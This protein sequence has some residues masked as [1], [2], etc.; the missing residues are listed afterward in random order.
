MWRTKGSYLYRTES[1]TS[2]SLTHT[3]DIIPPNNFAKTAL[4]LFLS[5]KIMSSSH[6]NQIAFAPGC[7]HLLPVCGGTKVQY[8]AA[9]APGARI[10]I[11]HSCEQLM[12]FPSSDHSPTFNASPMPTAMPVQHPRQPAV[13]AESAM[14]VATATAASLSG[15]SVSFLLLP[16]RLS[17][18]S[19]CPSPLLLKHSSSS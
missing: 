9:L 16:L 18:P 3:N 15:G 11:C 1:P 14:P 12:P 19:A 10:T 5:E 7:G 6:T 13:Q 8:G 4:N 2:S 17:F